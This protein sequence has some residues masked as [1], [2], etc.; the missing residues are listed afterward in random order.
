[1]E[2]KLEQ[3]KRKGEVGVGQGCNLYRFATAPGAREQTGK[4][5][6]RVIQILPGRAF[7]AEGTASGKP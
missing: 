7:P 4:R 1:M 6:N 2:R 3:F 5:R